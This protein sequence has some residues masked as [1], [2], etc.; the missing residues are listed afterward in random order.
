MALPQRTESNQPNLNLGLGSMA[1]DNSASPAANDNTVNQNDI[2]NRLAAGRARSAASQN[3]LNGRGNNAQALPFSNPSSSDGDESQP[4]AEDPYEDSLTEGEDSQ[5]LQQAMAEAQQR[6]AMAEAASSAAALGQQQIGQQ[7]QQQ[8]AATME[9][10]KQA[11]LNQLAKRRAQL[12]G[13]INK[14]VKQL[15]DFKGTKAK[16]FISFFK[17]NLTF[18]IDGLIGTLKQRI[19]NLSYRKK[20]LFLRGALLKINSLLAALTGARFFLAIADAVITWVRW[21]LYTI[22]TIII[23]IL[24]LIL[25]FFIIPFAAMAFYVGKIPMFKGKMTSQVIEMIEKL[26]KQRLAWQNQLN[27]LKAIVATQDQRAAIDKKERQ[28]Q[29]LQKA[30]GRKN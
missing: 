1:N 30:V 28:V 26:K 10:Q 13:E 9:A 18:I 22:E 25:G 29:N 16:K 6:Q 17:P 11:M 21:I 24:L 8:R 3:R 7:E 4:E 15:N 5:N 20:I 23:P 12:D 19:N 14:L 2:A 27:Q